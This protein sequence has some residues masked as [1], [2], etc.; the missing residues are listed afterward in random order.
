MPRALVTGGAGFIGSNLVDRL[1][2]EGWEVTVIDDLSTGKLHN[3]Q[4]ARRD[5]DLPLSFQR[6]DIT[7]DSL[8]RAVAKARPTVVMHLAAQVGV[9]RSMADPVRD[10]LVNVV[11]TVN[12]L[13]ACRLHDVEKVVVTTSGAAIYGDPD[14]QDLPTSEH[15]VGRPLSPHAASRQ[16]AE[17]H[18]QAFAS[19]YGLRWTSL[20]LAEVYG[21]RQDA[22]DEVGLVGMLA[23][24]MVEGRDVTI[25]G[26]GEQVRDLVF[27]AD[28]VS[29]LMAAIERGDGRRL[30]VG[31][32]RPTT[33]NALFRELAGVTGYAKHPSYAPPPLG[34][35]RRVVLDAAAAGDALGWEPQTTLRD[36]LMETVAWLRG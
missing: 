8:E 4:A 7:S 18:L 23:A 25:D 19:L 1:L 20:A 2:G 9:G 14:P 16:A 21:P 5:P 13:E 28:V 29:A 30:G 11:G 34:V 36:G 35:P 31:T 26:D 22:H 27:V 6:L 10:A 15:H 24:R 3:L 33:I 12:L 17:H 32:G